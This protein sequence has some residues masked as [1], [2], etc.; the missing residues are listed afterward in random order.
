[1]LK[2]MSGV[3]W[4]SSCASFV[5][6][7]AENV[8]RLSEDLRSGKYRP[9]KPTVIQ[10]TSPKKR[11]AVA[12]PFRDRVFQRSL[13]DNLVYPVMS[14]SWIYDNAACQK[15]KGTDFSR[16]R[17]EMLMR[18]Q[19]RENDIQGA[20]MCLDVQKYYDSLRHD[21]VLSLFERKLP[22]W[23][24]DMVKA[25]ME[26]Q[27]P[28]PVGFYPGSQLVQIAGISALDPVDHFAKE[29]L[30]CKRYCR[31]MDDIRIVSDDLDFLIECKE[32][33]RAKLIDVH[34]ELHPQ[35]SKWILLTGEIPY[36]GFKFRLTGSG[37]VL[38]TIDPDSPK[39]MRRKLR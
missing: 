26:H 20:C 32:E 34:L 27:Y 22:P 17:F 23:G 5:L 6:N 31:Y 8:Y 14:R 10:I 36:L 13:N 28:G 39:R 33:I 12:T 35:K 16:D 19:Y 29:Q 7:G 30:G 11:L 37:K 1:M 38:R 15:D 25:I 21:Y 3:M 9:G 2:C 18:S 24:F 4:K